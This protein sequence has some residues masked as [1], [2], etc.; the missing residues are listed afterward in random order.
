MTVGSGDSRSDRGAGPR[1]ALDLA[2]P[3]IEVCLARAVEGFAET[4]TDVHPSLQPTRRTIALVAPTPAGL[5]LAVLEE[6][7]RRGTDGEVA[8]GLTGARIDETG[9]LRAEIQ[10]VPA[11]DAHVNGIV[12]PLLSWHE[13][14]LDAQA[15]GSWAGRVAAR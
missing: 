6:C 3:S 5:L 2:G 10:V 7:L 11:D 12:P 4:F 14:S 8:V 15:D 13:V 9:A 1:L